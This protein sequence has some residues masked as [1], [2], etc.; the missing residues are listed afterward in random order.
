MGRCAIMRSAQS[1]FVLSFY[2]CFELK[3]GAEDQRVKR[4]QSGDKI[5]FVCR[6][7]YRFMQR[8]RGQEVAADSQV[9]SEGF[10]GFAR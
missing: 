10:T 4:D 9:S 3:R 6:V 2:G 8:W 1:M 5:E 7:A